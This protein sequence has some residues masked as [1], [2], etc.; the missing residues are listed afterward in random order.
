MCR[1]WLIAMRC[2]SPQVSGKMAYVFAHRGS[3]ISWVY[4]LFRKESRLVV[5]REIGREIVFG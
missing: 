1:V 3:I 2:P 5:H 4:E